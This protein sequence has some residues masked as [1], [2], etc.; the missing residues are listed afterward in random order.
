M[1]VVAALP[2]QLDA[3]GAALGTLGCGAAG[4]TDS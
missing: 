1:D 2:A 3:R 4:T